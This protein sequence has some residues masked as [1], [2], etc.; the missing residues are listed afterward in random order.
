MNNWF[1]HECHVDRTRSALHRPD[2]LHRPY[3]NLVGEVMTYVCGINKLNALG[4]H[5]RKPQA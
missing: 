1:H 2:H 5:V 3:N 4:L